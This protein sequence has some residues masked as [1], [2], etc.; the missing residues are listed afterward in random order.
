MKN[1]KE[2]FK[3]NAKKLFIFTIPIILVIDLYLFG[4][5][6]DMIRQPSD[7]K[8]IMGII[9]LSL[10]IVFNYYLILFIKNILKAKN[11]H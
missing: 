1:I 8:V 11:N 10:F 3:K 7:I 2:I 4:L 6:A 5:F 9:F